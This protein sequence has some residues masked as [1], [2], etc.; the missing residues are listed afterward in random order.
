MRA[1]CDKADKALALVRNMQAGL[2]TR[3]VSMHNVLTLAK[4]TVE[5]CGKAIAKWFGSLS[6]P[7]L[8]AAIR[9]T[10]NKFDAD[11]SGEI[12]RLFPA[13]SPLALCLPQT[14]TRGTCSLG[15]ER[16]RER[17]RET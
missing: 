16:V 6:G 7:A 9:E 4:E 3:L 5:A 13:R 8:E 1:Q 17:G 2:R 15:R 14:E 10:F 11:G 12:D